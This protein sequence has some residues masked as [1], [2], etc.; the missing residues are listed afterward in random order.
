MRAWMLRSP[1]GP[2]AFHL[3]HLP[4]PEPVSGE[5][6][7]AIKAFGLNRS[8]Y[9][10]RRGMSPGVEL[11]R[12]LGIECVGVVEEAPGTPFQRGQV[13]CALMGG[14]GRDYHGSYAEKVR[15]PAAHVFPLT[16]TLPWATLAALPEMFQTCFGALH[17]GLEIER[18]GSILIRGGTSSIGLL[19][20][21]L[22]HAAGLTVMATSRRPE[23]LRFLE[24]RGVDFALL[25]DG[26]V[27]HHVRRIFP[28]GVER[29][30]ELVGAPTLADSLQATRVGGIVCMVGML[31]NAWS[32][33]DFSPMD[34]IP[35]GV[36]LTTYGGG[37]GDLVLPELQG[38]IE[39]VELGEVTPPVGPVF[40]FEALVEAHQ[41]MDAGTAHGKM[42]VVVD[43]T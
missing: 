11:P 7:I 23:G 37:T 17:T 31:S 25:D 24:D 2:E 10:T 40:A 43:D 8:E 15:V 12:V 4:D 3:E 22:A 30:L 38:F 32:L 1:G 28:E 19:T 35:A 9:F 41:T 21:Q 36:K 27:A 33:P 20:A 18:A 26:Q 29:V 14:M 6:V 16:T 42:V 13:V 34:V 39:Q 5:V